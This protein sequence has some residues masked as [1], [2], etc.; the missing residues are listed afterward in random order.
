M[1]LAKSPAE[2]IDGTI[3]GNGI[4]LVPSAWPQIEA[5]LRRAGYVVT[6]ASP[7]KNHH[8]GEVELPGNRFEHD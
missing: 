6:E 3:I 7:D 2:A 4:L 8:F 5:A 1:P